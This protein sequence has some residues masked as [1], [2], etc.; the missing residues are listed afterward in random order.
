[1]SKKSK[2]KIA[3]LT[4]GW[5]VEYVMS[6]LEGIKSVT[7][8]MNADM[9]V[10]TSYGFVDQLKRNNYI[11]YNIYSLIDY[12]NFDGVI[13]LSNI[14]ENQGILEKEILKIKK[15]GIPAVSILKKIDG[16]ESLDVDGSVGLSLLLQHTR[17]VHGCTDYAYIGGPDDT[18]ES[19]E[20]YN[21]FINF[22]EK[23]KL[24]IKDNRIFLHGD[25]SYGFA[26]NCANEILEDTSNLPDIVVCVN[27]HTALTLITMAKERGLKIPEDLKVIGYDNLRY[28]R[29]AVPSL[30]SCDG[31]NELLGK[32]AALKVLK[33][34]I[35]ELKSNILPSIPVFAESCGCKRCEEEKKDLFFV[36]NLF[37][38]DENEKFNSQMRHMEDL[39]LMTT[40]SK[41]ILE[42]ISQFFNQRHHFEGSTFS[43][44]LQKDYVDAFQE[45]DFSHITGS[46]IKDEVTSIVQIVNNEKL[47]SVTIH[48]KDII[49]PSLIDEK[50]SL[51][52]IIPMVLLDS[53]IGYGV[54]KDSLKLFNYKRGYQWARNLCNH[55]ETFKQKCSYKLL[56]EKYLSLST[57][58]S[59][60]GVYNRLGYVNYATTLFEN[61]KKCG[62]SSVITFIDINSMKTINDKFG[63]LQGDFA[64]KTVAN[65][66]QKK[67]PENW[68]AVRYGGDEFLIIGQGTDNTASQFCIDFEKALKNYNTRL[69]LP[70]KLSASVGTKTFCPDSKENLEEA[71]SIVDSLMY[72]NKKAF[73]NN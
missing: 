32:Y 43:L 73:H 20:R 15:A 59:L 58:D 45:N 67:L 12:K 71:V 18:K 54:F 19:Q 48:G 53:L 34:K 1:M 61:N 26:M 60:S 31:Q 4:S 70:Y 2:K 25:Y 50:P 56:S 5:S 63:H 38:L 9:Y 41:Q 23:N 57:I 33:K 35:P 3:I 72:N 47:P 14:I 44:Q 10:F 49:P 68:I 39:F 46:Y 55:F 7:D 29:Q 17:D 28:A 24:T 11:G 51:Y 16:I 30:S 21:T 62:L 27:D 65:A 40:D 42:E 69:K 52:M 6:V 64:I 37:S 13:I 66:I 36:E 8:K 22:I